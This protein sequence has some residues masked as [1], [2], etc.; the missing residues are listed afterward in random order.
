VTVRELSPRAEI[1]EIVYSLLPTPL[2]SEA[3]QEEPVLV[4]KSQQLSLVP[5]TTIPPYGQRKGW[6][7]ST[8]ADFGDGGA[9]PEC[10]IAQYPQQIGK[11]LV[12]APALSMSCG[13]SGS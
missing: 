6:R 1:D 12:R 2:Y 3:T 10:H 13:S 11:K 9:Y 4:Q 7:P 8:D 5:K